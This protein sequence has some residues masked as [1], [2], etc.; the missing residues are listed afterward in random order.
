MSQQEVFTDSYNR[1]IWEDASQK[2]PLL[3]SGSN[4]NLT[5]PYIEIIRQTI[6][7]NKI[8]VVLD[9]D[10]GNWT[11]WRG[12]TSEKVSNNRIDLSREISNNLNERNGKYS[13]TYLGVDLFL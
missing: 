13:Q 7:S 11:M 3:G 2:N 1:K 12:Y 4:Q 9:V 8:R 6:E 10:Q 5:Y